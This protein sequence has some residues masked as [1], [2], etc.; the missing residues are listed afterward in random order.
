[1]NLFRCK[2]KQCW[3]SKLYDYF[4]SPDSCPKCGNKQ[5]DI[6]YDYKGKRSPNEDNPRWSSAMGCNVEEIPIF[7]K[8]YPDSVYHPETGD[9]LVKNRHHKIREMRRRGYKEL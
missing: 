5:Y 6:I 3:F 9:C 2:N 8:L 7:Q 1:M 4:K